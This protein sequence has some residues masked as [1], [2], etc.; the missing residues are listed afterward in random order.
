MPPFLFT[1]ISWGFGITAAWA[2]L[3]RLH[4]LPSA[5]VGELG[6]VVAATVVVPRLWAAKWFE[7]LAEHGQ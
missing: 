5:S 6:Q 7:H 1:A 2:R 4:R 3:S